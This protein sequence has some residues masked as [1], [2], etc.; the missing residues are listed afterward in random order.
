MRKLPPGLENPLDT[1]LIDLADAINPALRKMGHTPNVLT[2]YSAAS[3]G[4]AL[5]A[6]HRGNVGA[7][8]V[9]WLLGYF[10]DVADGNFARAYGMT[11]RFG[12][13][14]DHVT[15][16]LGMGGLAWVVW[17]RYDLRRVPAW[18]FL[19]ASSLLVLNV[20]HVGCQQVVAGGKG[21]TLDLA[22]GSCPGVGSIRWTR[23]L[24]FASTQVL[25][26]LA[27][28]Y[29]ERNGYKREYPAPVPDT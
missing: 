23:W 5:W 12:D 19:A 4:M 22:R 26:V 10:W 18:F 14:Y 16:W 6:L 3:Q 20:V 25:L 8:A 2:T 29:L 27:V 21:E 13:L 7:F 1:K 28:V 9:L 17:H 24:S 15:D 11:T